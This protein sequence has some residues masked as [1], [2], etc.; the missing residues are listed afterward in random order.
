[1]VFDETGERYLIRWIRENRRGWFIVENGEY[2]LVPSGTVDV[3]ALLGLIRKVEF[4][5]PE[6]LR[7][8]LGELEGRLTDRSSGP[9]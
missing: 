2:A 4:V 1:M 8:W 3:D 7:S 5:E 9:A 6:S